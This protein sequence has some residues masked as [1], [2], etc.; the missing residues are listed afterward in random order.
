[1]SMLEWITFG[2]SY[3]LKIRVH[4]DYTPTTFSYMLESI[5]MNIEHATLINI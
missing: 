4:D 5:E 1:M 3:N 2:Y